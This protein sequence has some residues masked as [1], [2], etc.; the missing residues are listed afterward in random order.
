[1]R[2][3]REMGVRGMWLLGLCDGASDEDSHADEG[4]R[5][6]GIYNPLGHLV[7]P[8]MAK[9]GCAEGDDRAKVDG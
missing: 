8:A 2:P 5:C 9:L 3:T 4:S 7:G 6:R 1:M